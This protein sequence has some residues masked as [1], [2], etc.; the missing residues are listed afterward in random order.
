VSL[1]AITAADR[2]TLR[3]LYADCRARDD[4]K[5]ARAFVARWLVLLEAEHPALFLKLCALSLEDG[6]ELSK[7]LERGA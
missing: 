1:G 7:D 3:T 4:C 6:A 2:E 5:D